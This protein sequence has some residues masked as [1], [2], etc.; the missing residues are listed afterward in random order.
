[1]SNPCEGNEYT[2]HDKACLECITTEVTI[3]VNWQWFPCTQTKKCIHQ[4]NRCD[5]YPHPDCSY[6]KDGKMIAEGEFHKSGQTTHLCQQIYS[7][8]TTPMF[9]PL[10][11]I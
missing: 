6:E 4:K 11:M 9:K 8:S 5:S 1:M 7:D 10:C 3:V 2:Y